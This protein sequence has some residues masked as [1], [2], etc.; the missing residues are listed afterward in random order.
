M[1]YTAA[2]SHRLYEDFSLGMSL[3]VMNQNLGDGKAHG[4]GLG[5]G[6]HWVAPDRLWDFGLSARS[7]GAK[8]HWIVPNSVTLRKNKYREGVPVSLSWGAARRLAGGRGL[9]A[10]DA[11]WVK[12][13]KMKI[14]LGGEWKASP[15]IALRAG[16]NAFDPTLGFGLAVPVSGLPLN[17]DYAYQHDVQGVDSP[18]WLALRLGF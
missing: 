2:Y 7:L 11:R 16:V 18:H 5:L 9:L 17:L 13:Q 1:T 15:A 8:L 14:H 3:D 12:D 6:F 10:A 4:W